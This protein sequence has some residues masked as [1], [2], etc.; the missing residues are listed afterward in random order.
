MFN[1]LLNWYWAEHNWNDLWMY[2]SLN[3]CK[4]CCWN[5]TQ[6]TFI[7]SVT[8]ERISGNFSYLSYVKIE[9]EL[10]RTYQ[11][12]MPAHWL[13]P[14]DRLYLLDSEMLWRGILNPCQMI[15]LKSLPVDSS[16]AIQKKGYKKNIKSL[17][18]LGKEF[19]K[20]KK[21]VDFGACRMSDLFGIWSVTHF[22]VGKCSFFR[23]IFGMVHFRWSS[24]KIRG[25]LLLLTHFGPIP[26]KS[27]IHQ[28]ETY[29]CI[30]VDAEQ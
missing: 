22:F 17:S 21:K 20:W 1:I 12:M 9:V 24:F 14:L 3:R 26:N 4:L 15:R 5:S 28:N 18:L 7:Q 10:N 23:N 27:S 2:N 25:S 11:T 8:N 6:P 19:R 13:K 30:R 29:E 16:T